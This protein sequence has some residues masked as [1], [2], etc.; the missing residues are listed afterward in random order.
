MLYLGYVGFTVPFAFAVAALITGRLYNSATAAAV[1]NSE[2]LVAHVHSTGTS[3]H[4][5]G[6]GFATVTVSG[7]ATISLQAIRQGATGWAASVITYSGAYGRTGLL[8]IKLA[9]S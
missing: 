9:D 4:G 8:A 7:S 2:Q 3:M 5:S 1:T 6:T